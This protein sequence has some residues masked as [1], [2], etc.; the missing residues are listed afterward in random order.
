MGAPQELKQIKMA[1][2][3]A[4]ADIAHDWLTHTVQGN[5][6]YFDN[7]GDWSANY[8][9]RAATAEYLLF[10]N[11]VSTAKYFDAFTDL[12]GAQLTGSGNHAYQL[13][14]PADAIP[15]AKGF[16]SLTAYVPPG[17]TL[18]PNA[19]LKYTVAAYTPGLQTNPDGS[20]TIFI[21]HNPPAQA[22]MLNWL[23]VPQGPFS[24]LL[25]IYG[26]EG[27]TIGSSYAP[28]GITSGPAASHAY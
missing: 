1:T 21:Q 13:T 16:W 11:D 26:P 12:K 19:A 14:F 6:V 7:I 24:V 2:Q 17:I 22:L 20:I 5:W 3:A 9:D 4:H 10:G 23:P 27:N 25:R 28:P 18:V 8:L 15:Q